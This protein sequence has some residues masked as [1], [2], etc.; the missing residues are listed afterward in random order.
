MQCVCLVWFTVAR[1]QVL[2]Y[3]GSVLK[4]HM[5]ECHDIICGVCPETPVCTKLATCPNC[6]LDGYSVGK[7]FIAAGGHTE[8][9]SLFIANNRKKGLLSSDHSGRW[10]DFIPHE[11]KL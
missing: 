10:L 9:G 8:T 6:Q 11:C 3:T 1:V 4:V 2:E 5:L 7:E